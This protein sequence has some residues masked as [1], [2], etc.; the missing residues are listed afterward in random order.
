MRGRH[1]GTRGLVGIVLA[2]LAVNGG[3][4][5]VYPFLA[6]IA[7]GLGLSVET[8]A[9]LVASRSLAGLAGPTVARLVTPRRRRDLMLASQLL[10]AAGCVLIIAPYRG[11]GP[12]GLGMAG[13]GFV[14]TGLA[15]PVF[16][17]PMQT[18]VTAHVPAAA[19]GRAFGLTELS[20]A[21]SLALTVPAAGVLIDRAGWRS[22]FVLVIGMAVVGALALVLTVPDDRTN[23]SASRTT[24]GSDLYVPPTRGPATPA[25]VAVCVA[26]GLA[27]AAAESLLMVHGVWLAS[28]FGLS[29]SQIATSALVIVLAELAGEGLMI[30]FAD[31]LGLARTLF[32]ALL[33]SVAAYGALGLVGQRIGLA[34][35]A[36]GVLFVAFEITVI[37]S[38]AVV[39][40]TAEAGRNA[41]MLGSLMAAIA[42][43]NAAGAAVGPALFA[44][45]GI[46]LSGV[47]SALAVAG[48]AALLIRAGVL[49]TGARQDVSGLA[50]RHGAVPR[51]AGRAATGRMRPVGLH[52][53]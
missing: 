29:V 36:I 43:G 49:P 11:P 42:C 41:G 46:R 21:L 17:L 14:A 5:V 45:G 9:L 40:T 30:A 33:L 23:R 4:R 39:S 53:P 22:P 34:L 16:D 28:D 31:R 51:A 3:L 7:Y 15:R 47:V 1:V 20:W 13:A 2:R 10:L 25:A 26:A 32:A 12:V 18:W 44:V 52:A 37:V 6:V 8:I 50:T 38:I 19:R 27:V 24:P 48:A 35:T